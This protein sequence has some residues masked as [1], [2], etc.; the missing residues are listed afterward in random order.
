M[1]HWL[2]NPNELVD[3]LS[4]TQ[5]RRIFVFVNG[6]S[7]LILLIRWNSHIIGTIYITVSPAR[8]P[9]RIIWIR[10]DIIYFFSHNGNNNVATVCRITAPSSLD[11]VPKFGAR[12][13]ICNLKD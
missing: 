11:N 1:A 8:R 7:I 2:I 13:Y 9:L 10:V 12:F 4:V 6:P 3:G 5:P